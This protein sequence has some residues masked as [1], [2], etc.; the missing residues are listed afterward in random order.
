MRLKYLYISHDF[1]NYFLQSLLE[2]LHVSILIY[3]KF[4]NMQLPASS[5]NCYF[6]SLDL[7]RS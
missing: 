2:I 6:F 5:Q 4:N 1:C 3:Y 7:L